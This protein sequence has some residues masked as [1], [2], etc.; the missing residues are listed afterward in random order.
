MLKNTKILSNKND[1]TTV[2]EGSVALCYGHFN[3]IHPGHLRYLQHAKNL[4]T[5]LAV[6][7]VSD[8]DLDKDLFGPHFSEKERAESVEN[9]Q[10]VDHVI[11]LNEISLDKLVDIALLGI[12]TTAFNVFGI[13]F[14]S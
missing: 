5:E 13:S 6:A 12:T 14:L 1:V 8:K 2:I 9:L 3:L 11:I 7:V 10:I 4:A